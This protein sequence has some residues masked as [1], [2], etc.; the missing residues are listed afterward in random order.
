MMPQAKLQPSAPS[1]MVRTW[2]LSAVTTPS[3]K[4]KVSA[5]IKPNRTSEI[6][7]IGSR[8]RS[9]DLAENF[10][11]GSIAICIESLDGS[12]LGRTRTCGHDSLQYDG[13][14]AARGPYCH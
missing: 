5:M 8:I 6:R 10:A 2:M 7:S 3:V 14:G 9:D 13:T 4:V 12:T 11:N 1:S